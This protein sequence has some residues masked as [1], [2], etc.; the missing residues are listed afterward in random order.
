MKTR[1]FSGV[2]I[3]LGISAL[4]LNENQSVGIYILAAV[5]L[6]VG[7]LLAIKPGILDGKKKGEKA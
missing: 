3:G 5:L 7:L 2:L 6:I 1:V 4:I